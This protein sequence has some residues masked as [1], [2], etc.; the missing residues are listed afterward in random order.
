VSG[1]GGYGIEVLSRGNIV[2]NNRVTGNRGGAI[3]FAQPDAQAR[4]KD[5]GTDDG[6]TK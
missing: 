1:S 2:T 4:V 6:K 3:F 5:D